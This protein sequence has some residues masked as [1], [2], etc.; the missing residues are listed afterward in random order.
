MESHDVLAR[1]KGNLETAAKRLDT[2][3]EQRKL[4]AS[5]LAE[6]ICAREGSMS[7]LFSLFCKTADTPSE[8]DKAMFCRAY[9]SHHA[10]ESALRP[11]ELFGLNETPTAGSHGKVAF[12]RNRYNERAYEQ[13]S[14][15]LIGARAYHVAEFSEACDLV[16]NGQCSYCILPIE[17]GTGGRLESFYAMM[18]RYDLKICAT[19][20]IDGEDATDSVRYALAGRSLPRAMSKKQLC[21]LEFS[22]TREDGSH[23]TTLLCA[24][25]RLGARLQR[26]D[27]IPLEYDRSFYRAFITLRIPAEDAPTLGL[28]LSL[29]YPNYTPIGFY[30]IPSQ[31]RSS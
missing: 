10:K 15:L 30:T 22:L 3:E 17:S 27:F 20:E 1:L 25:E 31:E 18:D 12:V 13:F 16:Y 28:Y 7:K 14:N 19:T 24:A 2:V 8:L 21:T 11:E 9:F 29:C 6:E 23:L 26:M 5:M 4:C